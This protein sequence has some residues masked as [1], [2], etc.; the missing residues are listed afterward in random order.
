MGAVELRNKLIEIIS[1]SDERFL[2]MVNAL[3]KTYKEDISE[4]DEIVAYTI[5]GESLTKADIIKN[6]EEA[7]QSIEKG[8]FKTHSE[9]RQKF[10]RH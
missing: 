3:H 4:E 6:N 10:A 9:I 7:I 5:K 2:R 8:E 1:T